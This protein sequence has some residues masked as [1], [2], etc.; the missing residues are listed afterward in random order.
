MRRIYFIN[1]A[2]ISSVLHNVNVITFVVL[3]YKLNN[4]TYKFELSLPS[5]SET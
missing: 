3:Q 4:S 2:K 1:A 5:L